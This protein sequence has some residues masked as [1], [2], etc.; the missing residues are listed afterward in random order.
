MERLK[1]LERLEPFVVAAAGGQTDDYA[2][3][4]AFVVICL[5]QRRGFP[6]S[7]HQKKKDKNYSTNSS[8]TSPFI[9]DAEL[10]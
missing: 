7:V 8:H 5:R 1:R 6:S 2:D 3:G 4:L 9:L 10:R